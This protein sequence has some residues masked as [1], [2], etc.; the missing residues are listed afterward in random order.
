MALTEESIKAMKCKEI[1]KRLKAAGL[2]AGGKK[3]VLIARLIEHVKQAGAEAEKP[4]DDAPAVEDTPT[5]E[6]EPAVKEEAAVEV[7]AA[8]EE[9][10]VANAAAPVEAEPVVEAEK[11]V[12]E[13]P[14]VEQEPAVKEEAAAKEESVAEPAQP[15]AATEEPVAAVTTA[16]AEPQTNTAAPLLTATPAPAQTAAA[17]ATSAPLVPTPAAV[18][19]DNSPLTERKLFCGG[20]NNQTTEAV[21]RAYLAQFGALVE[22]VVIKDRITQTPRGYGFA[23]FA[24]KADTQKVLTKTVHNVGGKDITLKL[25]DAPGHKSTDTAKKIFIGGVND[26]H[27]EDAVRDLFGQFGKIISVTL[28]KDQAGR[29]RGFGF[30]AFET[31][32]AASAAIAKG[33]LPLGGAQI[34]I[35]NATPRKAQF[36]RQFGRQPYQNY[37]RSYNSYNGAY[38]VAAA[39]RAQQMQRQRQYGAYSTIWAPTLPKL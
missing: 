11:M 5:A 22:V 21:L 23:T 39:M 8:V 9:E 34:T 16:P 17:P 38:G 6:E 37:Q 1:Q 15:A 26:T 18:Q 35:K 29:S 31:S 12:E 30:L 36:G 19:T 28:L 32:E 4:A 20:L 13:E 27:P 33:A 3:V 24:T 2:N 10:P 7:E 14:A 25:A